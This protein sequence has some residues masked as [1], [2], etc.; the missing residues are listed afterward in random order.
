MAIPEKGEGDL[1]SVY[2]FVV[3][4]SCKVD[5]NSCGVCSIVMSAVLIGPP[6][7][8]PRISEFVLAD[9]VA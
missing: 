8:C 2:T 3:Y 4:D 7:E 9:G 5:K 6:G 1:D